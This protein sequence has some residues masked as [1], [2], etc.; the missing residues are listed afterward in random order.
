MKKL[1]G[2]WIWLGALTASLAAAATPFE[3]HGRLRVDGAKIVGEH[4][5]SVSLAGNSL[6]WSQWKGDFYNADCINWLKNDWHSSIIRVAMGVDG[7]GY[8]ANP[9]VERARVETVVDAC[10]AAGLY[11]I[12][13]WH[14]HQAQKHTAESVKFFTAMAQKY[15]RQKNIVYEIFNEPLAVSWHDVVKPYATAVVAAIRA[16]DPEGLIV[17]GTPHWSQDVDIAASDPIA[18]TN[19]AYALHFYAGTHKK[20]IRDKAERALDKGAAIFVTEWGTCK[21]D[22]NGAIDEASVTAW[23]DFMRHWQLSHCNW[24]VSDKAETSSI[25]V[26]GAPVIGGW[27]DEQLTPSGKLVRKLIRDWGVSSP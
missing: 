26:L 25:V 10:T 2:K 9:D 14:D 22:G 6:F 23:M 4:G 1:I 27:T 17:V 19:I 8:L 3:Q 13:D 20:S 11:V 5:E 12:I 21:A 16:V 7:G 15:G 24:A 18:G